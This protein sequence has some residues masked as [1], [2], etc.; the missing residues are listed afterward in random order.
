MNTFSESNIPYNRRSNR[1]EQST[2][3]AQRIPPQSIEAEQSLLCAVLLDSNILLDIVE[4]IE[5][6]HFYNNKH[7]II[8]QAILDLFKKSEPIDLVTITNYLRDRNSLDAIGGATSLSRL[9]DEIPM[10]V[11][12]PQYANIIREKALLRDLISKTNAIA[13]QCFENQ[14]NIEAVIDF[15]ESSIYEVTQDKVKPSF[16]PIQDVVNDS[17]KILEERSNNDSPIT[18][19][20]TGFEK[21][22]YLTAGLQASD[23]IILAARPS[24]GKTAF[25]LN[26]TR[27]AAIDAHMPVAFFSLEMSKEQLAIRMLCSEARVDS[28]KLRGG[29][30]DHEDWENLTHAASI[31]SEAP[32]FIDDAPAQS[33]LQIRAKCRRLHKASPL[34]LIIIDYLQLMRT[35]D[36]AERRD[37]AIGE[38]SGSLKALAKELNVPVI[39]LSQLNRKL[40][41][42]GDKRPIL[43]DLRESGSLEQDADLVIFIYR[44]EVYNKDEAN[45][46]KGLAEILLRKQRNGP[47]GDIILRFNGAYTRF[48]DLAPEEVVQG[49]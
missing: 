25:A 46:N 42:R 44:D 24:M 47:T 14:S 18:G 2:N 3:I 22:N 6:H 1:S 31:I 40:E 12:P 17:F 41:E 7:Q 33:A 19:I 32:I 28:S 37:L 29:S 30:F 23:L 13:V 39:A 8:F 36:K 9:V 5:S 49:Y 21:L 48:D 43:S 45:P 15:A 11:N 16:Y 38:I 34:G 35:S 27:N 4:I 20:T 10:A 26:L